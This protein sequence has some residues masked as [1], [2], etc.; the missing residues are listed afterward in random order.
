MFIVL[1]CSRFNTTYVANCATKGCVYR[2]VFMGGLY[3]KELAFKGYG[4]NSG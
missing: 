4:E 3:V 1:N 2:F